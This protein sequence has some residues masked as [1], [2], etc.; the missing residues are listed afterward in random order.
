MSAAN[1]EY[2]SK[3]QKALTRAGLAEPVLV[4][5]RPRLDANI[6]QLKTMLPADMGFRIVA[7]SLP[8]GPLL[9]HIA[10]RAKTDR[11]M[12]FNAAMALQML[13]LM[14]KAD[15]LI[16]KPLPAAAVSGLFDA[17]P[18]R[19]RAAAARQIQFLVDT[20]QRVLQMQKLAR[21]QK[22][23]LRVNLE[24][25]VGLHRGGMEPGAALGK[26]LDALRETPDL[27]LTGLM[28][29]EPH[30]SKI[31]KQ[32]GWRSRARKGAGAVFM[33]A[34]AQLAARHTAAEIA[35]MTFNMA[36]SPTFGLYTST[37]HANEISAGSAPVKPSDFDLPILKAFQPAAFIATPA[38]KVSR[39]IRLPA[40][41]YTDNPLGKPQPGTTIFIHGGYWMA[42]PVFPGRLKNSALFGR[43]SNQEMLVG[44]ARTDLAVDDFVFLRPT[45]S[46]AV[47]LQF[48]KIAVFDGRRIADIWG[49]LPVSA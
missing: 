41:E 36:G 10:S 43:S 26:M 42:R 22:L 5:D 19:K 20:P 15:Q 37:T 7:K 32:A 23:R 21:G 31:P 29:Y 39:G 44:P 28:G 40:H 30:L 16:G 46:E 6:R 13:E 49:P 27:E 35:N 47:F 24:I 25:D 34:R 17:L 45:Q 38:L 8:C 4:I 12:S 14:P 3:V 33:A 9:A 1:T 18:R 48:P 11:L 2:F